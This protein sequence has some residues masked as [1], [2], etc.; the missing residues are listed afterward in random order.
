TP[1]M[2]ATGNAPFGRFRRDRERTRV[3]WTAGGVGISH[4]IAWLKHGGRRPL[5]SVT[6]CYFF[7]PS[8]EFPSSDLIRELA[9]A[10]GAELVPVPD[11]PMSPE[12]ERRFKQIVQETG[13]AR[14]GVSFCGP[15]GLLKRVQQAMRENG[16]PASNLHYE[17]FEFR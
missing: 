2:H 14:V 7:T 3:D 10:R 1:G 5:E 15:K 4:F 16:V 8:R 13:P 6:W 11:G 12:F 17:Y 9:H